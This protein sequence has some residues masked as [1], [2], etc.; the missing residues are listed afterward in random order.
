MQ[1]VEPLRC[2]PGCCPSHKRGDNITFRKRVLCIIAFC[3]MQ[4]S[5][6][7]FWT[8]CCAYAYVHDNAANN[9]RGVCLYL[10]R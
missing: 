1:A 9:I 2:G 6:P 4:A 7:A 8:G 3:V 5:D 10:G